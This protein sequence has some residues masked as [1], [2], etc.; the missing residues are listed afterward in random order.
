MKLKN[1]RCSTITDS[2]S[3]YLL[4]ETSSGEVLRFYKSDVLKVDYSEIAAND[5]T[6][7]ID[8]EGFILLLQRKFFNFI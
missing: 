7:N 1:L 2:D 4:A 6:Q 5:T 8:L 3:K